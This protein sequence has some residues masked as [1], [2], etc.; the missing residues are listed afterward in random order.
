[1]SL[2]K[3]ETTVLK[4]YCTECL[5]NIKKSREED[6]ELKINQI[7]EEYQHSIF[8]WKRKYTK[9]QI[10]EKRKSNETLKMF[11]LHMG[12]ENK[13]DDLLLI[14]GDSKEVYVKIDLFSTIKRWAT[15]T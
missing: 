3:I 1:M 13:V 14:C 9:E 5:E 6:E 15:K 7:F 2:I 11:P 8:P 10:R 12:L 4:K